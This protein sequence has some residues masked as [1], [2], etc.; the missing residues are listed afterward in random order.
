MTDFDPDYYLQAMPK[1]LPKT[2]M[3]TLH[4]LQNEACQAIADYDRRLLAATRQHRKWKTK[5]RKYRQGLRKSL[6]YPKFDRQ[7]LRVATEYHR[8]WC[9]SYWHK[10]LEMINQEI[11]DSGNNCEWTLCFV[12]SKP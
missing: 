9:Q 7:K 5:M 10:K 12:F 4:Y 11:D 8:I 1:W 3:A 6:P 2:D